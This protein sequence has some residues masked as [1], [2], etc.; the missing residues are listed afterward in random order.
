MP[1]NCGAE[2][3]G[4]IR[5]KDAVGSGRERNVVLRS[6]EVFVFVYECGAR[7]F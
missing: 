3:G 7:K 1:R 6:C 4:V 5:D 2:T